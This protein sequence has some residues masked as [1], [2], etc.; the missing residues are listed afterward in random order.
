MRNGWR[1]HSVRLE[2]VFEGFGAAIRGVWSRNPWGLEAVFFEELV[3]TVYR[4]QL[5]CKVFSHLVPR[6][7]YLE[8]PPNFL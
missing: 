5:R 3:F 7:S 6:T 1:R 2:A 8:S 4:L